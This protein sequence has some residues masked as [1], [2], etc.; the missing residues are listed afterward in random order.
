[1]HSANLGQQRCLSLFRHLS[2][3]H[4][5]KPMTNDE[6]RDCGIRKFPLEFRGQHQSCSAQGLLTVYLINYEFLCHVAGTNALLD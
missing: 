2:D 6:L 3:L 1:V 5:G 4:F